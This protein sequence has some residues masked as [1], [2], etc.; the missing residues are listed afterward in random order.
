MAE[1]PLQDNSV[2]AAVFSLSLMGK[3]IKDY[4]LDAHRTLKNG[5]QL[6]VYH[7]AKGNNR[8]KFIKGIE[9]N[10]FVVIKEGEIYKWHYIWA[11]KQGKKLDEEHP[12]SFK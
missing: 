2:D 12:I 11:I 7:P 9:A 10:G 8:Q 3:N 4:I 5:G 6:V 1:S